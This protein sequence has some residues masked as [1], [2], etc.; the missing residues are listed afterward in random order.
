MQVRACLLHVC[1][2]LALELLPSKDFPTSD[3]GPGGLG[4][5]PDHHLPCGF[6]SWHHEFAT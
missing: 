5:N 2:A 4:N 1:M 6:I 3:R